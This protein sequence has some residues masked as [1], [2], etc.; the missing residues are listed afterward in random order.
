M[1]VLWLA[2]W[3]PNKLA[4]FDGDFIQR[5]ARALAV[6]MPVT[7]IY[8]SQ[9]GEGVVVSEGSRT[10][11]VIEGVREIIIFFRFQR[12][13]IRVLDKLRYNY[14][15]FQTFRNAV[16]QLI[17]DEGEPDL[18]HVH[19][20][21]KAGI[22]ARWIR[23]KWHIP[24]IVSEHS[25]YD[26][27]APD[28]FFSRSQLHQHATKRIFKDAAA[29]SI[30]SG[31]V[32]AILEKEFA[33]KEVSVIHNTVDTDLFYFTAGKPALFRFIHVSMF[34]DEKNI[35][36]I[37]KAT[38]RLCQKRKDFEF[39]VVGPK[40]KLNPAWLKG[41]PNIVFAGQLPYTGVAEKMRE[42][43]AFVLFS[44]HENFPC[45]IVEALCSGLPCISSNV[46][47]IPEAIND[48]NGILVNAA[49]ENELMAAMEKMLDEYDKF[50]RKQIAGSAKAKYSYPSIGKQFAEMYSEVNINFSKRKVDSRD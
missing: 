42:S 2:S 7:V 36:G 15:Y 50:D 46:G 32:A 1:K 18:V 37:L 29:V 23:R 39:V 40:D 8:V 49:N 43:S 9:S 12:T 31:T 16:R 6:H 24:Y 45:V 28:N 47:G 38:T 20:P 21:M 19:V 13:G 44:D 35:E 10:D 11:Q 3:Y 5:H 22:I 33:L 25:S 34:T 17:R 14:R 27:T 30:V 48:T 41:E 4:P 26:K